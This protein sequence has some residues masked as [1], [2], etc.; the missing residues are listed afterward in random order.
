VEFWIILVLVCAALLIIGVE[1]AIARLG[2]RPVEPDATRGGVVQL[3]A[4]IERWAERRTRAAQP[5]DDPDS[6]GDPENS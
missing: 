6:Q 3:A 2:V 5:P 1:R 4:G